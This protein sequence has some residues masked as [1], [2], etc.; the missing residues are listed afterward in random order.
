MVISE[1]IKTNAGIDQ[2]T[3]ERLAHLFG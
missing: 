3:L 2:P 1:A